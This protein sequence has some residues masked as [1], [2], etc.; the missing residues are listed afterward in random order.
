M[1]GGQASHPSNRKNQPIPTLY[2]GIS[3]FSF[4]YFSFDSKE[5]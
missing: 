3:R 2:Q 1:M 4:A 5:K